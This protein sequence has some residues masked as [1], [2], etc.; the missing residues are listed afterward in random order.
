[1]SATRSGVSKTLIITLLLLGFF[2][3]LFFYIKH[4]FTTVRTEVNEDV[5]VQKITSMGKLELVK[6]SM[7]DVIEKKQIHTFLPDERVLFLAVGE[8]TACIDLTKVKKEDI[9]QSATKDTVTVL[10]PKAEICYVKLDHQRSKVYDITGA[11][12]PGN[13]KNMV[14]DIYKIAEKRLLDNANEMHITAKAQDN[15]QLIFKPLLE[16]ISGKKVVI[17][18]K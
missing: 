14:E 11:L 15:A 5:M 7:K 10:M 16:N 2:V 8:V 1:M 3:F 9:N 12:F 18:F 6:Y 17:K 13:A 4:Q